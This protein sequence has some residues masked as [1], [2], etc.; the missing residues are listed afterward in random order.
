M[1]TPSP[2]GPAPDHA[3]RRIANG[4]AGAIGHGD[5]APGQR[6]PSEHALAEQFGVNRHT[7]RRALADLSQRGLVRVT[8]GSGTRVEEFA[9]DLVLGK[10]PRH[11]HM[12]ART[13]HSGALQ[14]LAAA[15]TRASAEPARALQIASRSAVLRLQ[16]LGTAGG[17]PLHVGERW[18]P[19]PR[20]AGLD[21]LVRDSGSISAAFA[22]LGVPDYVRAESRITAQMPTPEIAAQ[23]RQ[24]ASRPVL[25]VT[26]VNLDAARVPIEYASTWFAGD[27]VK[28]TV[29]HD[30]H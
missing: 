9:V 28:F 22:A 20:F 5:Y 23:L 4:I 12:L 30:E 3:W 18:F 6:L 15:R 19:L 7:V 13:G 16:V 26:S 21:D 8:R 10:R 29:T 11:R 14:V 24:S 25:H 1:P 27:R 17:Q 2:T